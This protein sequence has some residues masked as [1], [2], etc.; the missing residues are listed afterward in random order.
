MASFLAKIQTLVALNGGKYYA[1][2]MYPEPERSIR[3]KQMDFL[4]ES[5]AEIIEKERRL[6]ERDE[7]EE[8]ET[9]RKELWRKNPE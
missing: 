3:K 8:L 6:P 1:T 7:G 5:N 9:K 4:S 2:A